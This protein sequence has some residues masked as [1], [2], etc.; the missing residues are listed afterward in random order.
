MRKRRFYNRYSSVVN[1]ESGATRSGRHSF[2]AFKRLIGSAP[3]SR[4]RQVTHLPSL[5]LSSVF[6]SPKR[7]TRVSS[8]S[9]VH[10][11][12]IQKRLNI[13]NSLTEQ[14]IDTTKICKERKERR[15]VLFAKNKQGGNHKKPTYTYK[16]LVRC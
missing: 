7:I 10:S 2:V 11:Y 14:P 12:E 13:L 9:G 3:L 1:S 6:A 16:S 15:E 8:Q 5:R 4:F